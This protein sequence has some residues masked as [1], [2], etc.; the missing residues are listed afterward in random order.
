MY[1]NTERRQRVCQ[2]RRGLGSNPEK[3]SLFQVAAQRRQMR[4]PGGGGSS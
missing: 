1:A 2:L 3:K 4:I